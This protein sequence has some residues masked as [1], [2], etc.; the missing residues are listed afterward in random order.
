MRSASIRASAVYNLAIAVTKRSGENVSD[1]KFGTKSCVAC[2]S[3]RLT[4]AFCVER[5]AERASMAVA[6]IVPSEAIARSSKRMTCKAIL[7]AGSARLIST[8]SAI[9]VRPSLRMLAAEADQT[10][11]L[12]MALR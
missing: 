8:P 9:V 5:S 3:G 10:R 7:T 6:V 12:S 1:P 4:E 11:W 2:S